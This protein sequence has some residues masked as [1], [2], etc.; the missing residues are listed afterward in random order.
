MWNL[1]R[2][3]AVLQVPHNPSADPSI[4]IITLIPVHKGLTTSDAGMSRPRSTKDNVVLLIEEVGGVV[5]VHRHGLEPFV[6][7]KGRA[8]PFPNTAHLAAAGEA[9][10]VAG[11]RSRVPLSETNVGVGEV[12]V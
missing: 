4:R 11:H 8:G 12:R 6:L 9:V 5:W 3:G 1:A 2:L 7:T 10:A